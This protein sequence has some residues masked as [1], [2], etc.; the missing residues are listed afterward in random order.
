MAEGTAGDPPIPRV[1]GRVVLLAGPGDSTD[2]VANFLASRVSDL[3]V[4][5]EEPSPPPRV[6]TNLPR[7]REP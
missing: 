2:I 3:V 7:P 4:V 5:M 1:D 6:S